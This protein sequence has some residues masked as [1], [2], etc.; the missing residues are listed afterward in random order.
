MAVVEYYSVYSYSRVPR[1]NFTYNIYYIY[2]WDVMQL[3]LEV[4]SVS[5]L[6][7]YIYIYIHVHI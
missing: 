7:I 5:L 4:A 2:I 3:L 6:D 1:P